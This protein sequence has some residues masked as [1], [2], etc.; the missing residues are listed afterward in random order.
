MSNYE[1]WQKRYQ[2]E[3]KKWVLE[4]EKGEKEYEKK[5]WRRRKRGIKTEEEE[6]KEKTDS[7]KKKRV[8]K[9]DQYEK[10]DKRESRFRETLEFLQKEKRILGY[11]Q[12]GKLTRSDIKRG[13]D[14]YLIVMNGSQR[15]VYCVDITGPDWVEHKERPKNEKKKIIGIEPGEAIED[16]IKKI[17]KEIP[18]ISKDS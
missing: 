17:E 3:R 11:K 1:K 8:S 7:M 2:K 5:E 16:I 4:I 12:S 13:I 6:F 9:P 15:E 14:F 18:L 10:G